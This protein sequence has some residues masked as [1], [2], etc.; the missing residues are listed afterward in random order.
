[1]TYDTSEKEK[2]GKTR[3]LQTQSSGS[4]P[5][6][7]SGSSWP[8]TSTRQTE[9]QA[10]IN[11]SEFQWHICKYIQTMTF[12]LLGYGY[13]LRL[14]NWLVKTLYSFY[15]QD[16]E[17][18]WYTLAAK[19]HKNP[20][21]TWNSNPTSGWWLQASS[22]QPKFTELSGSKFHVQF[23]LEKSCYLFTSQAWHRP[24]TSCRRVRNPIP[25]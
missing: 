16:Q 22:L 19:M 6:P 11:L 14:W 2:N 25:R 24:P 10:K 23:D 8:D 17:G 18:G 21:R 4:E 3:M 1:M 13:T 9:G 15:F 20:W 5:C 12:N 7:M